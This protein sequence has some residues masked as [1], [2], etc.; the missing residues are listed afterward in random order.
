MVGASG[1][2]AGVLGAYVFMFPTAK[3]S[4]LIPIFFFFQ[5]VQI[6][7]FLFLGI[8][9]LIQAVSGIYAL[10]IASDAGGVAWWAHIGGFAAGAILFPFLKKPRIQ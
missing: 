6:P 7:A 3:I 2:I 5:V 4:T 10:N 9:F 1:A 8:W